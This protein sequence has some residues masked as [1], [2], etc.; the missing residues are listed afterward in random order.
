MRRT[1]AR[2]VAGLHLHFEVH[3]DRQ[4]P[5]IRRYQAPFG[6][7]AEIMPEGIRLICIRW[8]TSSFATRGRMRASGNRAAMVDGFLHR[9]RIVCSATYRYHCRRAPTARIRCALS[10]QL[11]VHNMMSVPQRR[12]SDA[13]GVRTRAKAPA[14]GRP[15]LL[16]TSDHTASGRNAGNMNTPR[17]HACLDPA[18][19]SHSSSAT[20][21]HALRLTR[22][23]RNAL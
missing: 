2:P 5:S 15:S 1:K 4:Q 10:R 8:T 23:R 16:G 3:Q 21:A 22:T 17:A 9:C 6:A 12:A 19:F 13:E 7:K 18:P 14:L 11:V 20:A